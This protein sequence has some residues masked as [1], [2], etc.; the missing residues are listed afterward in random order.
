MAGYLDH[1]G[2]GE[3]RRE[4]RIK[5]LVLTVLAVVVA[6]GVLFLIFKNYR[7]ERQVH[8]FFDLLARQDYQ[9]AYALW[10]CTAANPCRDYPFT[11]F[12]QDWGPQSEHADPK[13]FH[14]TKTR[15]CGSGVIVTVD[16]DKSSNKQEDKLW[17]QRDDLTIGFS[18]LPGCPPGQ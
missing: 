10:G 16:S 7:Q 13:S 8:R 1:Y 2:A 18:P 17:V 15:A 14:I 3:E 11:A 12:M 5:R 9:S 4:K 6:A